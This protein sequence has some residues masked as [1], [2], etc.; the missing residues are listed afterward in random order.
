[1]SIFF[2]EACETLDAEVFTGDS[3]CEERNRKMLKEYI[4]RWTRQIKVFEGSFSQCVCVVCGENYVDVDD[5]FDTCQ[6]CL[7][8]I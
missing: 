3:L 5:G 4:D 1:M 7:N 2:N 6:D 8:K